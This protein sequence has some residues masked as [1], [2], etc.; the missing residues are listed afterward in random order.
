MRMNLKYVLANEGSEQKVRY[1]MDLSGFELAKGEFP[2]REPVSVEGSAENRAGVV[3]LVLNVRFSFFTRC[4]RC[5][6]ELVEPMTVPIKNVVVVETEGQPTG[7][8]ENDE[9][10]GIRDGV[11]ELDPLVLQSIL[12]ALPMKHLCSEDCRGLCPVCGKN[13][14]EGDC[15][16]PKDTTDPRLAKLQQLL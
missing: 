9:I 15:G 6:A 3:A 4:D 2:F 7:S 14:N 12:L 10:I 16:C 13:L 5:C 8:G 11:L 1:A